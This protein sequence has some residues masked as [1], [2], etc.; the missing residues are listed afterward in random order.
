[1]TAAR[2]IRDVQGVGQDVSY[3]PL[4]GPSWNTRLAPRLGGVRQSFE[5]KRLE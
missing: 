5:N 2:F 4:G 1:M 3:L